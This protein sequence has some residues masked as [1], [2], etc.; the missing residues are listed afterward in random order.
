MTE[1]KSPRA[2]FNSLWA[3]AAVFL[4]KPFRT[5]LLRGMVYMLE[6]KRGRD[7]MPAAG[8]ALPYR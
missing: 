6:R 7:L 3:G 2:D 5:D 8:P 4:P 1:V